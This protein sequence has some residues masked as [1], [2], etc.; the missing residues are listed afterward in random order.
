MVGAAGREKPEL[1]VGDKG[2][3]SILVTT[4]YRD[5]L[6]QV[7]VANI[8]EEAQFVKVA[9]GTED[10][11][12]DL[13][14]SQSLTVPARSISI[15]YF[16]VL[17]QKTAKGVM[18]DADFVSVHRSDGQLIAAQAVQRAD[19]SRSQLTPVGF[20]AASGDGTSITYVLEPQQA[21]RLV[22]VP[23]SPLV[24]DKARMQGKP[25]KDS[26]QPCLENDLN[27]LGLPDDYLKQARSR[28]AD[29]FGY[30]VKSGK[31][32]AISVN[33]TVPQIKDCAVARLSDYQYLFASNGS[34]RQGAG[35]VTTV[36]IY[37]PSVMYIATPFPLVPEG[38]GGGQQK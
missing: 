19:P 36:M 2:A 25:R 7:A 20:L 29:N 28:L 11:Q 27:K 37:N 33:Y 35:P 9:I 10:I 8:A 23:K 15:V 21:L 6:I 18:K 22:F 13:L 31:Q 1:A 26:L 34:V 38:G 3:S 32:A 5:R 16:P 17:K 4:W 12:S 14:A 30:I 24:Q